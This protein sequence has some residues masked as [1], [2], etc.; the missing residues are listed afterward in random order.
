MGFLSRFGVGG[1]TVDLRLDHPNTQPGGTLT[2]HL[3]LKGGSDAAEVTGVAVMLEA[4]VEVEHGDEE[5]RENV[6][7]AK[8]PLFGAFTLN[9]GQEISAP[10]QLTVPWEAPIT[11]LGGWN[12]RGMQVGTR[13][14]V[15]IR[16]AVDPT[17]RDPVAIHPLPSQDAVLRALA[18]LG[19]QFRSADLEK[20]RLPDSSLPFYQ[21]LE[22]VP[23]HRG[24]ISELEVTFITRPDAMKVV[25]EAN[26]RGGFLSAGGDAYASVV[27]PH[28]SA[29]DEGRL[30]NE[31]AAQ[32]E[33]LAQRRGW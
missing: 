28:A 19:W 33:R 8:Q 24:S 15:D 30:R 27:L 1:P 25:L 5:W 23:S 21:E 18:S 6:V 22:F 7:F 31:L 26:R 10:V 3:H 14:Q 9:A 32:V 13:T 11:A 16:G 12:L 17:D 29:V 2:G 20:G 4:V